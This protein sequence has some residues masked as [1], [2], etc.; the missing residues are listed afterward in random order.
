MFKETQDA[1]KK[2]IDGDVLFGSI[3]RAGCNILE[4][5][6]LAKNGKEKTLTTCISIG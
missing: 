3:V 6:F 5:L 1:L 4:K 2:K